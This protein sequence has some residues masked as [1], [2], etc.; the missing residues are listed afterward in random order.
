M[1]KQEIIAAQGLSGITGDLETL[2]AH[3]IGIKTKEAEVSV[4]VSHLGGFPDLPEGVELPVGNGRPLG[5]V[6]QFNLAEVRPFDDQNV[7]PST[8]MLYFFY[9]ASGKTYGEHP[10][11]R[12]GWKVLYYEGDALKRVE[13]DLPETARFRSCAVEFSSEVTLPLRPEIFGYSANWTQTEHDAYETLMASELGIHHRLLGHADA[14]QDDMHVQA[15]LL[16]NGQPLNTPPTEEILRQSLEWVLLFQCDTDA[17]T[18]MLW[19]NNGRLYFWIY[20]QALK[21]CE[22]DHTWMILQSE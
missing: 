11:D 4:G 6:A 16:A 19:G 10:E 1:Q 20:Q 17:N 2:M 7:L 9:D 8:G 18:G 21:N 13:I 3:S 12:S 5:F 15:C 22:F 14:I